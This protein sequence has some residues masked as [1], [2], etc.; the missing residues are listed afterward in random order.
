[1]FA[2]IRSVYNKYYVLRQQPLS[3]NKV[4]LARMMIAFVK[5]CNFAFESFYRFAIVYFLIFQVP[6]KQTV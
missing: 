6:S 4:V 3:E 2:V 1:M 5:F